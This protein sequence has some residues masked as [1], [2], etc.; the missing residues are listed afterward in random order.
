MTKHWDIVVYDRSEQPALAAETKTRMGVSP[1]WAR[2]FRVNLAEDHH[3]P[4]A[5]YFMLAFP[6]KFYLWDDSDVAAVVDRAPDYEIDARPLLRSYFEGAGIDP[7][8]IHGSTFVLLFSSWLSAFVHSY[9]EDE[10]ADMPDWILDSQLYEAIAG[11]HFR[12]EVLA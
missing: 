1:A 10:I 5:R 9:G 4:V 3:F 6:D 7:A 2:Q 11:G 8:K 12:Q